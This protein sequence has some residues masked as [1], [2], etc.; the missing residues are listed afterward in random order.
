MTPGKGHLF[1]NILLVM[2]SI[3]LLTGLVAYSEGAVMVSVRERKPEGTRIWL[4]VPALLVEVGMRFVPAKDLR[5]AS[6]QIRPWLP[7]I[8]AASTELERCPDATLV[9][10]ESRTE[11]VR[12]SKS[13]DTLEVDVEDGDDT[14]HVSVPVEFVNSMA[15]ELGAKGAPN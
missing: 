8:R 13:G 11:H 14:V 4:P 15:E 5:D 7:A 12:V 10:V 1:R 9:E 6:A 3:V 2:L